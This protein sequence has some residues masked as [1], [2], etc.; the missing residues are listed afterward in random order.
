MNTARALLLVCMVFV[1]GPFAVRAV[2]ATVRGK[3]VWTNY[4]QGRPGETFDIAFRI[5]TDDCGA[6][7]MELRHTRGGAAPKPAHTTYW[8]RTNGILYHSRIE[9]AGFGSYGEIHDE[10]VPEPGHDA[11]PVLY[12]VYA[13]DCFARAGP[14]P[15]RLRPLWEP[16]YSGFW[17]TGVTLPA[18][19]DYSP[20]NPD[21]PGKIAFVHDGRNRR[22]TRDGKRVEYLD[23]PPF[24][25]G[26]VNATL[27]VDRAN[28]PVGLAAP[29][30]ATFRRY[31]PLAIAGAAPSLEL[32]ESL[33]ITTLESSLSTDP[34]TLPTLLPGATLYDAR[35]RRDLP[36]FIPDYATAF[37]G[38]W[39]LPAPAFIERAR[40]EYLR[41][42]PGFAPP[43]PLL[44]YLRVALV[45]ALLM[46][47]SVSGALLI[48]GPVPRRPA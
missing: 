44:K 8:T 13:W 1:S 41:L 29:R 21:R 34:I 45:A 12:S 25:L 17:N 38:S 33:E 35:H 27:E 23:P 7:A 47:T 6:Y 20:H 16:G 31:A 40:T 5:A 32:V 30:G 42:H 10:P 39:S 14:S 3:A 2:A 46:A 15:E 18:Q 28:L 37:D 36:F 26:Y 19:F 11:A 43:D 9:P 24:D 48:R 4:W 22:I